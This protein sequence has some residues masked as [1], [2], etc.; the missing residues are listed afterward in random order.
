[1]E[2]AGGFNMSMVVCRLLPLEARDGVH[3]MAAD[4]ALLESA[5]AGVA[6]LR[7]YTWSQP[8]VSLGYFQPERIRLTDPHLIGLTWV[9]R[10]S[11]GA[12]LIHD[13]EV[14]YAL[15]VPAGTP[16]QTGESWLKRMH[17]IIG[18]ALAELAVL[19]DPFKPACHES[20]PF[21]GVLCF[22][23][24]TACDL[25]INNAKVVGSAQRRQRGALVQHGGI[26]LGQ[27]P[28]APVL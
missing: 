8:T 26:L 14:T 6:S 19:A 10:P 1:M 11:G 5:A 7:F 21:T 2:A 16:W 4:E 9:R 28:Y 13:R 24:F 27:S 3:N 17:T 18:K 20:A 25:M 12:A 22:Q 23:H 15:A